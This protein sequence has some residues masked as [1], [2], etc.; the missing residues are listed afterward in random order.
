MS[1]IS[2]TGITGPNNLAKM[3]T[4]IF[5]PSSAYSYFVFILFI[6][7]RENSSIKM[8]V[9]PFLL[10]KVSACHRIIS[11]DYIVEE[12]IFKAAVFFILFVKTSSTC[13]MQSCIYMKIRI[14]F[15]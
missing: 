1:H 4:N 5:I 2:I 3:I 15:V 8:I 6:I 13:I 7:N 9:E 10:D 12:V 11:Y 14:Y